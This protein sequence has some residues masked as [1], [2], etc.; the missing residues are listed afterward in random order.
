MLSYCLS[1]EIFKYTAQIYHLCVCA[2]DFNRNLNSF[3]EL[4]G[5]SNRAV[6][7]TSVK[8]LRITVL[9]MRIEIIDSSNW[10]IPS[11]S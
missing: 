2:S 1:W 3:Q 8:N 4:F 9:V 11:S 10:K 7:R 5:T 6:N